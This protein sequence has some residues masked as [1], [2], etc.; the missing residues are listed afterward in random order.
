MNSFLPLRSLAFV[1][2]ASLLAACGGGGSSNQ[3]MVRL[4]LFTAPFSGG[5]AQDPFTD[6][7]KGPMQFVELDVR[8]DGV[9]DGTLARMYHFPREGGVASLTDLPFNEKI[10]IVVR[11]YTASS[12]NETL[13]SQYPIAVGRTDFFSVRDGD[14]VVEVP[15]FL[16]RVNTFAPLTK[17]SGTP[18][19]EGSAMSLPAALVGAT[20]TTLPTG[21]V[22]IVGGATLKAGTTNPFEDAAIGSL[23]KEAWLYKPASGSLEPVGAMNL[24]RAFHTATLLPDGQ[25][26]VAGGLSL[27]AIEPIPQAELYDPFGARFVPAATLKAGRARHQATLLLDA[28]QYYVFFTGGEG[29]PATWELYDPT[30]TGSGSVSNGNLH[31]PRWNHA[32]VYVDKGLKVLHDAVYI[33]GGENND[34]LVNDIEFF[35]A[36]VLQHVPPTLALPRGG[37]TLATATFNKKRGFVFMAGGFADTSKKS[38]SKEVE[39]F[40]LNKASEPLGITHVPAGTHGLDLQIARGGHRAVALSNGDVVFVGGLREVDGALQGVAEGEVLT[41]LIK[42]NEN[43]SGQQ[44]MSITP[45]RTATDNGL[46]TGVALPATCTLDSG[47]VVVFGGVSAAAGLLEASSQAAIYAFDDTPKVQ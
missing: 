44:T 1:L 21:E 9:T 18:G 2:A 30:A 6:A 37:K 24:P 12:A 22:L 34:G 4:V 8:G 47:N 20:A 46:A 42:I 11:G 14:E 40:A 29:S 41:E 28:D 19:G 39:L 45:I 31:T 13:P 5:Q 25:V 32:D 33:V 16:S 23:S 26:L 10:Q 43:A 15:L 38:A 27:D 7:Q 17:P 36:A 3:E 35:D